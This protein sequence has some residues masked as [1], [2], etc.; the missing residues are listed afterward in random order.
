MTNELWMEL[1]KWRGRNN[2][3][4]YMISQH[5]LEK[6]VLKHNTKKECSNIR[7]EA[8]EQYIKKLWVIEKKLNYF[9][10]R[11]DISNFLYR[12][13]YMGIYF[14]QI[15]KNP[16][17]GYMKF[18]QTKP[19]AFLLLCFFFHSLTSKHASAITHSFIHY[20]KLFKH[21]AARCWLSI[22][23]SSNSIHYYLVRPSVYRLLLAGWLVYLFSLLRC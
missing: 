7:F 11:L 2:H 4:E 8:F 22:H 18:G 17:E 6:W 16:A 23:S 5:I 9:C 20:F 1:W 15:W 13:S 19:K 3:L 14:E 21:V 10:G 12:N